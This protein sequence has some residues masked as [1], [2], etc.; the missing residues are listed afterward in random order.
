MNLVELAAV[1]RMEIKNP[2]E[3]ANTSATRQDKQVVQWEDVGGGGVAKVLREQSE[4][5]VDVEHA[6]EDGYEL[7]GKETKVEKEKKQV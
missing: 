7:R 6:E 5:S 2:R 4:S 3:V 1:F